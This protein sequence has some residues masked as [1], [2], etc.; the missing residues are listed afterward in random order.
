MLLKIAIIT[1]NKT[2][3]MQIR[4]Y[5][6][7]CLIGYGGNMVENIGVQKGGVG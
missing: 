6:F 5:C 3:Q 4:F 2:S 7:Y 1:K